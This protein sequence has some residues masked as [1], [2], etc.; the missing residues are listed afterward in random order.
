MSAGC[1]AVPEPPVKHAGPWSALWR[2]GEKDSDGNIVL[3]ILLGE[4]HRRG[5][6]VKVPIDPDEVQSGSYLGEDE[7]VRLGDVYRR[8]S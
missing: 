7:I 4:L 3:Y 1:V 8:S 6:S 5:T 2:S